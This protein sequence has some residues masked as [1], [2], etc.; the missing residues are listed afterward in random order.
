MTLSEL[1]ENK[2]PCLRLGQHFINLCIKGTSNEIC[3]L[4]QIRDEEEAL[5]GIMSIILAY[6]WDVNDLPVKYNH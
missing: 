5:K 4:Y 2:P 1:I 3:R 6:N